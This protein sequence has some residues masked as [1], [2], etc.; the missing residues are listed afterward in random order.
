MKKILSITLVLAVLLSLP[1]TVMAA[2]S[3]KNADTG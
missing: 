2:D 3:E 1:I